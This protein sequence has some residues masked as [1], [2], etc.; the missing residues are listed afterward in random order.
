MNT[1]STLFIVAGVLALL[2]IAAGLY[3]VLAPGLRQ[4]AGVRLRGR[5]QGTNPALD[6]RYSYD[7]GVFTPAPYDS[8]AEYPMQLDS[9][10][11][12]FYGKRIR[13]LGTMLGKEPGGVLYDFVGSEHFSGFEEYYKLVPAGEPHYEDAQIG[14]KLGLHQVAQYDAGPG[15]IWPVYFPRDFVGKG[16]PQ[17]AYVE[18]WAVFTADDLFF[19]QAVSVKPL[20]S[21]QRQAC[22]QVMDSL[23]FNAVVDNA[24]E[25]QAAAAGDSAAAGGDAAAAGKPAA[26][27]PEAG[28]APAAPGAEGSAPAPAEPEPT[29]P[30]PA[31]PT[32]PAPH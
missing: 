7:S 32:E 9:T 17:T 2:V 19:F 10:D 4:V 8:R 26:A 13:G 23:K 31:A 1:K 3:V 20:D 16:A 21:S 14:G 18:G 28:G 30:A 11:F 5:L 25:A 12:S 29:Q 22:Q 27:T 24:D 6:V 15:S